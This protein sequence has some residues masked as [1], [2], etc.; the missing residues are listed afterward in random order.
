MRARLRLEHGLMLG[1]A[2]GLAGLIAGAAIVVRWIERGFGALSDERM[3]IVAATLV[4]VGAQIF[5][6]SF[7]LSI[8]GLRRR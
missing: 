6:A 8:L 5:F 3:A 1:G 2:I 4:I 7:L